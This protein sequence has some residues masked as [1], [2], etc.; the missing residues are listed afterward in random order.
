[1]LNDRT[2][3]A[4]ITVKTIAIDFDGVIH[5]SYKGWSNGEI[6][7]D[8]IP[9]AKETIE[10]L[11]KKGYEPIVFTAR[12]NLEPVKGW[13]REKKLD[14]RVTNKKPPAMCYID[15]RAIRFINWKD[16]RSYFI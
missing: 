13:L 16:I 5:D 2:D 4:K 10:E 7:G 6:Y 12:T 15:D 11:K 8:L 3:Y 9:G 14:I 1:M